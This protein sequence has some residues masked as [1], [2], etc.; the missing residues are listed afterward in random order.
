[1]RDVDLR[2]DTVTHPTP[3]MRRA[4]AEAEVGDDVFGDDPTLNRLEAIAADRMGKEAAVFVA[5]GTMGNLVSMLSH[6]GRGDEIILG[7]KAHIFRSEAGGASVL[8][9]ISFHTIPND[10]RGMLNPDDVIAA[11]RPNDVHQ[12]RTAVVA[13][14]NTQNACGGAVLTPE[15]T[16]TIADIAHDRETPL[17]IDGARIFNA[18]VALEAPVA[19]LAKDADSITFCLS[20]GLSCPI[21]SIICGSHD[22]IARSRRWRKIVGGSMRQVGIVAAAGIVALDTMVDRLAE[23]HA[24]ARKLATG[25]ADI[26]G[27]TIDPDSLQTNLVFF[28]VDHPDR[29]GLARKLNER[30]VK[31]GGPAQRWRYVTHYGI[32]SE[33]IDYTLDVFDATMRETAV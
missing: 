17:H 7:N 31:G 28:E 20:K 1:M 9:G 26:P 19:E 13:L 30:G 3:E 11:F 29:A 2:S 23:D 24:N 16:K 33:D 12:P 18:A 27:V 32:T 5:S 10:D 4:M 8:G 22:F 25:L 14:E 6:A 21:G 15:D